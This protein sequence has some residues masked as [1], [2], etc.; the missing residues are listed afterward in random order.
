MMVHGI[1]A[2]IMIVVFLAYRIP[3]KIS[4]I[5]IIYYTFACSMLSGAN[6]FYQRHQCVLQGYGADRRIILQFG[7]WMVPIMWRRKCF[8]VR[9]SGWTRY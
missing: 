2:I 5:Q 1:F 3:V 7:M 4:W 9:R 8:R 6:V